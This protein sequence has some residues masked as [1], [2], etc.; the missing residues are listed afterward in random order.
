MARQIMWALREAVCDQYEIHG[1]GRQNI[2]GVDRLC[3]QL[4]N[5]IRILDIETDRITSSDGFMVVTFKQKPSF[6]KSFR[7]FKAKAR[8]HRI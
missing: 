6:A 4:N 2:I 7:E 5:W 3:S 1:Y 8:L